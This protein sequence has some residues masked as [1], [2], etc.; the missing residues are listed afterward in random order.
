VCRHID[1]LQQDNPRAKHNLDLQALL[2]A[3][4][5]L[6][7][8]Y[9]LAE[10]GFAHPGLS[11][12]PE[13]RIW[14]ATL[15]A[16]KGAWRRA[17]G[18]IETQGLETLKTYPSDIYFEMAPYI[19]EAAL[20]QRDVPLSATIIDD[21][22]S[23]QVSQN[24]QRDHLNLLN[25]QRNLLQKRANLAVG[26]LRDLMR[27]SDAALRAQAEV[28]ELFAQVDLKT[29]STDELVA[30][31]EPLRSH[32]RGQ[33]FESFYYSLLAQAYERLAR[34]HDA[35]SRFDMGFKRT[36]DI[37]ERNA[38]QSQAADILQQIFSKTAASGPNVL[39]DLALFSEFKH[40]LPRNDKGDKIMFAL[41]DR[42]QRFDLLDDAI[43]LLAYLKNSR[44]TGRSK[45]KVI[46]RIAWLHLLNHHPEETLRVLAAVP[47]KGEDPD[48]HKDRFYLKVQALISLDRCSQ[49]LQLL[50]DDAS[51]TADNLRV[52]CYWQQNEWGKVSDLLLKQI[53]NSQPPSVQL[54]SSDQPSFTQPSP[55]LLVHCAVALYLA[56]RW[57]DM[58]DLSATYGVYMEASPLRE[59][60]ALL[61]SSDDNARI[62]RMSDVPNFL[63]QT[64][65]VS[66]FMK[67]YRDR[68]DLRESQADTLDDVV[69]ASATESASV[70]SPATP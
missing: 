32:W 59:T 60:F 33:R 57:D 26:P 36:P 70:V 54:G 27:S 34:W 14:L 48:E 8:H 46:T 9:E 52:D 24:L 44:L 45:E 63:K 6:A 49:A 39:K 2:G 4:C 18:L 16:R 65:S 64:Q 23:R 21:I 41:V 11:Q 42:L 47:Q 25:A 20:N 1:Q 31:L 17:V 51:L 61:T 28:Q 69:P 10:S 68:I 53:H 67:E 15:A 35:L 50:A 29:L 7:R 56:G 40:F 19:A 38:I 3:A 43:A 5:C 58:K 66:L 30:R 12:S 22:E 13:I 37:E 62:D 55:E